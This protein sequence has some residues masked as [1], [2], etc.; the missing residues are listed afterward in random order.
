MERM[1]TGGDAGP[2]A[3]GFQGFQVR[4]LSVSL[5]PRVQPVGTAA[6]EDM[7][8]CCHGVP[9]PEQLHRRTSS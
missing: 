5:R 9:F 4:A 6:G 8:L 7:E 3:G 2:G 1:E